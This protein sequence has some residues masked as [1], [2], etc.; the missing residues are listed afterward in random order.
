VLAAAL[1]FAA[2]FAYTSGSSF[3]LQQVYGLSAQQSSLIFAANGLGIVLAGQASSF[4]IGHGATENAPM[5]DC[6]ELRILQHRAKSLR[7]RS[8]NP[9]LG[10]CNAV[11]VLRHGSGLQGCVGFR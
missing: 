8:E 3:V 1:M 2:V 6:P 10:L 7:R 9:A 5:N 11:Q 4:L